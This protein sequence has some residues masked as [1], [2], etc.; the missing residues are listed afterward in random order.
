MLDAEVH[1]DG[2]DDDLGL[3]RGPS[4]GLAVLD[5]AAVAVDFGQFLVSLL[6][7]LG[8]KGLLEELLEA[9]FFAVELL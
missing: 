9:F 6:E 4:L 1:D 3:V 2:P 5:D 7:Q 8:A